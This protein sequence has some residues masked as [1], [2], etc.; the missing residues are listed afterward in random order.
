MPRRAVPFVPGQY[1]HIYNRGVNRGLIFFERENY[2]FFFRRLRE[3]ILPSANLVAYCLMPNHYHLLVMVKPWEQTSEV[4]EDLGGLAP[5]GLS[6]AMMRFSVSYTKAINKRYQR[7]GGLFQGAF[8]SRHIAK[9]EDLLNLSRY[10]HLNPVMAGLA[11]TPA[12][13]EFSSYLD[14]IGNRLGSFPQP[15]VILNQF[16]SPLA[17]AE[18][19]KAIPLDEKGSLGELGIDQEE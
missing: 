13:W 18:F 19:C 7:V 2:L 1:Y 6:M 14:Y 8:Q 15:G 16:P 3:H 4:L 12:D 17:Y 5:G 11:D 9:N 10:I